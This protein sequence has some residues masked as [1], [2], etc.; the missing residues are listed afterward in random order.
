MRIISWSSVPFSASVVTMW[1]TYVPHRFC[2][3]TVMLIS[4]KCEGELPSYNGHEVSFACGLSWENVQ[5]SMYFNL[6]PHCLDRMQH[7][8]KEHNV[9]HE[10]GGP[11][12]GDMP[13]PSG[14]QLPAAVSR[15]VSP[16]HPPPTLEGSKNI[17]NAQ[18]CTHFFSLSL[19]H[20]ECVPVSSST[21]NHQFPFTGQS[22]PQISSQ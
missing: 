15:V 6:N 8:L 4:F 19:R 13:P 20:V 18:L 12:N 9:L 1:R 2:C 11:S 14:S 21:R 10:Q 3:G 17:P 5:K 16:G 7:W 22:F